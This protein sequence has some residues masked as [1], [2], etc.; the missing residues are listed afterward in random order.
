MNP[1]RVSS[2][3]DSG[4]KA[5]CDDVMAI[6]KLTTNNKEASRVSA[7]DVRDVLG[8]KSYLLESNFSIRAMQLRR[9]EPINALMHG[10]GMSGLVVCRLNLYGSNLLFMSFEV[11]FTFEAFANFKIFEV[12]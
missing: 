3:I 7:N 9:N 4:S 6:R 8:F 5:R 10:W 11:L 2:L 12:A 1:C